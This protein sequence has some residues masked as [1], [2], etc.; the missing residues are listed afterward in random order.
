MSSDS[1]ALP[2]ALT[3]LVF[4]VAMLYSSVG[5]GGASGYLAVMSFLAVPPAEMS[6]TALILNLLVAGISY[7]AFLRAGYFSGKLTWPFLITSVPAAFLGALIHMPLRA[8]QL[9]L[10]AVLV[11]AAFRLAVPLPKTQES[12][13]EQPMP[14]GWALSSGALIGLL[15]GIVGIGGGIFLSP[16]II[17]MKWADMKHTAASSACF[18]LV[19]SAAGL[20]GRGVSNTVEMGAWAPLVVAAVMGGLTGSYLGANRLSGVTLRRILAAGLCIAA[21]KLVVTASH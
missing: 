20:C 19:N 4:I 6:T 13:G 12:D 16:L 15:S 7:L 11:F 10:A 2:A 17:L 8:Y 3:V 5:H 21:V 14:I 1:P 9:L 18:I